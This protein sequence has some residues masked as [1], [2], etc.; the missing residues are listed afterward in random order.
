MVSPVL[1]QGPSGQSGSQRPCQGS[2]LT[3]QEANLS[4][5]TLASPWHT[6]SSSPRSKGF[7]RWGLLAPMLAPKVKVVCGNRRCGHL[8]RARGEGR[9]AWWLRKS[10]EPV[11]CAQI[12]VASSA[13]HVT[14]LT[15][16]PEDY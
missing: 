4:G 10:P 8:F 15:G 13:N 11:A 6:C 12:L 16:C 2:I 9:L 5:P 14:A 1:P 7:P 3:C